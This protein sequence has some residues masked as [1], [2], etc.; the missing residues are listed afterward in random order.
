MNLAL[1]N[2][3][4]PV[5]RRSRARHTL[6]YACTRRGL[7]CVSILLLHAYCCQTNWAKA[8]SWPFSTASSQQPLPSVARITVPESDGFSQGTGTLV[9][10]GGRFGLVVTAW[11]VVRDAAGTVTVSFPDGFQST[12]RILKTDRDWDLAAL[13]IWRPTFAP[14]PLATK[15][16]H[17]GDVLTIAG[18]GSGSYRAVSGRCTQYVSPSDHHPFEMVELSAVAR[19]GDSGGPIFNTEGQLAGVLFG[20]DGGTTSGS[21]AGRVRLFLSTAWPP[22]LSDSA[23]TPTAPG[24]QTTAS[25]PIPAQS[26]T[27]ASQSPTSPSETGP[28]PGRVGDSSLVPLPQF[29]RPQSR[30]ASTE[31]SPYDPRRS[32]RLGSNPSSSNEK[33][34]ENNA[35]TWRHLAGDTFAEQIKSLLAVI[36]AFAIFFQ[37][38]RLLSSSGS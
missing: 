34:V 27:N 24:A 6:L 35:L 19:Q 8:W 13:M 26:S 36:G 11:H 3:K 2:P 16:P 38:T 15:A 5:A 23:L 12:A 33:Q 17:P 10:A 14:I 28:G 4:R 32:E 9:G 1:L 25:G 30:F 29:E 18:Y 37:L 7:L 22:N 21:H 20:S 31:S